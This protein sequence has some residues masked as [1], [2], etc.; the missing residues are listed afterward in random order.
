VIR[1]RGGSG[2]RRASP[3][4][5]LALAL[6]LGI[7]GAIGAAGAAVVGSAPP[8]VKDPG[9]PGGEGGARRP[10]GPG[11]RGMV[12]VPG[13]TYQMGCADCGAPDAVPIHPVVVDGFWMDETPVTNAAFA[14]FV[15]ATGYVTIAERKPDPKD[16]PDARPEALVPGS[17][18]F[19]PP[20]HPVELD[21]HLAW[22][23]YVPGAH[24]KQPEGPGSTVDDRADH[25]VVHVA[26]DDAVAYAG[27]VGKR[28]PTE[29]EYEHAARG[30][31][32]SA[33][34]AWGRELKPKGR[35]AANIWQGQ[36]P[37][38]NRAEDG[39]ARTSPVKAFPSNGYGLFDMGGNVWQWCADWYRPDYFES[40][41]KQG[42]VSRDPRGPADSLDPHEPG[43]KKR[44]Q[45]GGSFLCSERYCSR[46][47]L[48]SRGKGAPDS[49]S[50][51]VGFRC[52][53]SS[54]R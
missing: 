26:W 2:R 31:L 43:V 38:E 11:P 54:D 4:L 19:W 13:A 10:P 52:V 24:W 25:P 12:W 30:R 14:A 5:A 21:D 23:R 17:A 35:W 20:R 39:Y 16:F 22:W 48:G 36:F 33:R 15:K 6:A 49:G 18:V 53:K 45:K 40:L 8:S 46:Y 27:W 37:S 41:S 28:L 1:G 3:A 50:S 51:N 42:G 44:V 29:A 47:F 32:R 34:F 7:S 9:G